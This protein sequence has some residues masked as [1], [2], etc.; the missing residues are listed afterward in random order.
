MWLLVLLIQL[1]HGS[2]MVAAA[3][4]D[5]GRGMAC[6]LGVVFGAIV[7]AAPWMFFVI[8][9]IPVGCIVGL[10]SVYLPRAYRALSARIQARRIRVVLPQARVIR[11]GDSR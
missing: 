4:D 8:G 5:D 7:V 2:M 9:C 3:R 6:F 10:A 1:L 11:K